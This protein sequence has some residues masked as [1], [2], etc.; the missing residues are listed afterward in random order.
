MAVQHNIV[1]L[2]NIQDQLAMTTKAL[3]RTIL[4][5]VF[6]WSFIYYSDMQM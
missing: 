1:G 4:K 5:H 3:L 2:V 6:V